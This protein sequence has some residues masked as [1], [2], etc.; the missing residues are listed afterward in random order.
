MLKQLERL[1]ASAERDRML[2]E[3][4]ARVVDV[5]T[6]VTPRAILPVDADSML[7]ADSG[8]PA[9]RAHKTVERRPADEAHRR[10]RLVARPQR[11]M[12]AAPARLESVSRAGDEP[13]AAGSGFGS[14]G[15][16]LPP[17]GSGELLSLDDSAVFP[18][19][20]DG[21]ADHRRQPWRLGLRG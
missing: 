11:A 16:A 3:V 7:A 1:P 2:N 17:L 5:D 15:E 12:P 13:A 10:P 18:S 4:R 21:Q 9:I 8:I 19:H 6:G 20:P 14:S